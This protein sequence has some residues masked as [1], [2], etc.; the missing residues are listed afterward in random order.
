MPTIDF[1]LDW[2]VLA[3]VDE[4]R[5]MLPAIGQKFSFDITEDIT[6]VSSPD[7]AMFNVKSPGNRDSI[8]TI[9][10]Q[11]GTGSN[12]QLVLGPGTDTSEIGLASLNRAGLVV[13][14][15]FILGGLL[16]PPAPFEPPTPP[17]R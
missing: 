5:K 4:L 7:W 11:T 3:P 12:S 6:F 10:A 16:L 2:T 1:W 15:Q 13:Y 8:A 17:I 14:T 9:R